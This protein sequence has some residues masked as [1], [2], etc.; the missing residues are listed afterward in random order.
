MIILSEFSVQVQYQK[1][2]CPDYLTRIMI[3]MILRLRRNSNMHIQINILDI[4][5]N[6]IMYV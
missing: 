4:F 6:F 2:D 1:H 5:N 3:S